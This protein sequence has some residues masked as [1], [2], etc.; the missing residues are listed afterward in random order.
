MA[1][2]Y[3][4]PTPVP[5]DK[6]TSPTEISNRGIEV[7]ETPGHAAHHLA[8]L[9]EGVL[10]AGEAAG[11]RVPMPDGRPYLR[12]SA[13]PPFHFD[14]AFDSLDRLI[15]LEPEPKQMVFAH[16]GVV[17]DPSLWCRRAKDQ[18]ALWRDLA[19]ELGRTADSRERFEAELFEALMDRDS[20]YSQGGF[21]A[22]PPDLKVR[23]KRILNDLSGQISFLF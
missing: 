12:P 4:S 19:D 21:D 15:A 14:A 18:L 23:E 11:I 9:C 8:F 7:I 3:G 13:R 10:F 16:Y 22:L 6:V 1:D 2:I 17:N 5:E 20:L